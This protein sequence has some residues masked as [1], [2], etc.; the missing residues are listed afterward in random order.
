MDS[1]PA[2]AVA[3]AIIADRLV[4]L[5]VYVVRQGNLDRRQLPDIEQL[6]VDKKF[7]N[8]SVIL[9]GV[10]HR[11]STY[12]YGYGYGYG[13]SDSDELTTWQRR[14]KKFRKLFKKQR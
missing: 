7:H 5:T 13:Y 9:N 6:Y 11:K 8:M 12:G 1:T 3:D 10:T 2:L 14:W 4:D